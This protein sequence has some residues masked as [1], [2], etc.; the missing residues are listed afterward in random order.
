MKRPPLSLVLFLAVLAPLP[1]FAGDLDL[2]GYASSWTQD[3]KGSACSL[4][5]PG[6]RNRPVSLKLGLPGSPGE[7]ASAFLPL[8]LGLGR[9]GALK[10]SL[11]FFAVC[12]YVGGAGCPGRYFQAQAVLS[13]PAGAFC[14]GAFNLA[15]FSPFP[16]LMCA[17]ITPDGTRFGLTLHRTPL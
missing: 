15:D 12:P 13:G 11:S 5:V 4:P 1:A 8:E 14:A 6:E 9:A 10:V 3:C 17:G 2:S 7:A 16:V